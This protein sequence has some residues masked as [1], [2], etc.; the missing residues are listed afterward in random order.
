MISLWG[1]KTILELVLDP[2]ACEWT[3]CHCILDFKLVDFMLFRF[4]H[5]D[6]KKENDVNPCIF[7]K[8]Y[9]IPE[10]QNSPK[11]GVTVPIVYR[12]TTVS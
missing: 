3:Q 9:C 8:E 6:K 5:N 2:Q 10:S 11:L 12:G 4:Y 7:E 1:D